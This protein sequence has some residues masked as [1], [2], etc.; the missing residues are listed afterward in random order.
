M[1]NIIEGTS[2]EFEM[3]F[4]CSMQDFKRSE[5]MSIADGVTVPFFYPLVLSTIENCAI[6]FPDD[7]ML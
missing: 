5:E 3:F 2:G 1:T 7:R 6:F 4:T